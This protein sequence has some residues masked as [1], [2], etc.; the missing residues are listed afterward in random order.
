MNLLLQCLKCLPSTVP[1]C[2]KRLTCIFFFGHNLKSFH[3]WREVLTLE[4]QGR[5]L[6]FG[7]H[8][9]DL[10]Y[11]PA[12]RLKSQ[13]KQFLDRWFQGASGVLGCQTGL[14]LHNDCIIVQYTHGHFT[15]VFTCIGIS[16]VI[17]K[18]L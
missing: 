15:I 10:L 16:N 3:W 9:C 2:K 12:R 5:H 13:L 14:Q 17:N 8:C 4:G 1:W 7:D 11:F 18:I 6:Q